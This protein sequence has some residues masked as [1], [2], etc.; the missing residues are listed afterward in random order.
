MILR[1]NFRGRYDLE[2]PCHP[3]E[4]NRLTYSHSNRNGSYY[5][6]D[7]IQEYDNLYIYYRS[8]TAVRV[9]W[10]NGKYVPFTE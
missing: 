7:E 2:L 3:T 1:Y 4:E 8:A 6:I 9:I 5:S 10:E